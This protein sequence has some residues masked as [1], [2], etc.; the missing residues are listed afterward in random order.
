[1]ILCYSSP[2]WPWHAKMEL[3]QHESHHQKSHKICIKLKVTHW[4][5]S[6]HWSQYS[7]ASRNQTKQTIP[8]PLDNPLNIWNTLKY[9]KLKSKEKLSIRLYIYT[10][11]CK[12]HNQDYLLSSNYKGF[13]FWKRIKFRRSYLGNTHL[14]DLLTHDKQKELRAIEPFFPEC[15]YNNFCIQSTFAGGL[16]CCKY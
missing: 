15:D 14:K 1:M 11:K 10:H 16:G 5:I 9:I 6:P 7:L 4:L 2:N 13:S 3:I 12:N 8:V